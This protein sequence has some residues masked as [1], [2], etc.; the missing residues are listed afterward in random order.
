MQDCKKDSESSRNDISYEIYW[1]ARVYPHVH[2]HKLQVSFKEYIRD[3]LLFALKKQA[4][5]IFLCDIFTRKV[6]FISARFPSFL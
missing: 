3:S 2:V 4:S 6:W 1:R 5:K